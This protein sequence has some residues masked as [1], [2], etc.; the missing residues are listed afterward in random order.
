[1]LPKNRENNFSHKK[2]Q[3]DRERDNPLDWTKKAKNRHLR[4]N[5]NGAS[6][7]KEASGLMK[8]FQIHWFLPLK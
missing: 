3:F 6:S 5:L 8:F 2:V 4:K 7:P 1:M